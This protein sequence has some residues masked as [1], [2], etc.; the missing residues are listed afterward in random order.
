MVVFSPEG[1]IENEMTMLHHLFECGL[2]CFHLRKPC[3]SQN[4]YEIYLHKIKPIYH[5]LVVLHE[6]HHLVEKYLLKGIHLKEEHR[7]KITDT[8]AYVTALKS[9]SKLTISTGFHSYEALKSDTYSYDYCFLS[10]VFDS[11]SK[12]GYLGKG[13]KVAL[14]E[15]KIL[16][17]GGITLQNIKLAK[18]LGYQG[19]AL[20]G[21]V[22]KSKSP[23]E[24]F[25]KIKTAYLDA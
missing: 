8:K 25:I 7:L 1:N 15:Q 19:I 12:P 9:R 14:T 23:V 13:F 5:N 3:F 2:N 6:Y 4:D 22:W 16:A 20:L 18:Q 24:E 10:P 17:L 11:I 21:G